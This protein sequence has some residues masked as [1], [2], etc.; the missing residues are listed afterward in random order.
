MVQ[1]CCDSVGKYISEEGVLDTEK[2]R[3]RFGLDAVIEVREDKESE[4]AKWIFT[5]EAR[6]PSETFVIVGEVESKLCVCPCHRVG[7]MVMH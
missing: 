5:R 1:A 4:L 6:Y 2:V 3:E 7:L